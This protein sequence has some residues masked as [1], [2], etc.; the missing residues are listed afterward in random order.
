MNKTI[1]QIRADNEERKAR[2]A[3]ATPGDWHVSLG[4]GENACTGITAD[5]VEDGGR[6]IFV[7][8]VLPSYVVDNE[9]SWAYRNANLKFISEAKNDAVEADVDQLLDVTAR[10][11]LAMTEAI[12]NCET[13]KGRPNGC[14]RCSTFY[15][16]L[17]RV[18]KLDPTTTRDASRAT[19]AEHTPPAE[20][21]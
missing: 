3:A 19:T 6:Y 16:L 4:S 21:E 10:M 20:T 17:C 5:P 14:A 8:D 11:A 1:E 9:D 18:L 13:C 7:C 12:E 15:K 2:K